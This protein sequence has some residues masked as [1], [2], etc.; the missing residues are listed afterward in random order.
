MPKHVRFKANEVALSQLPLP[1]RADIVTALD[2][3]QRKI[4]VAVLAR[5][6]L[7]AAGM[8]SSEDEADDAA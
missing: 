1:L 3:Q 6:L 7:E 2:Q 8:V 5:L 4:V